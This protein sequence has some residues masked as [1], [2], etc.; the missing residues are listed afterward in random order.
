MQEIPPINESFLGTAIPAPTLDSLGNAAFQ[1]QM[2]HISR[3]SFVFFLG[4]LFT[5]ATGYLFKVYLARA[6]GAEA[7]GV[8]ALG[9]TII[10]LLG[11]FN[12]FGLPQ[13]AVRFVAAYSATGRV[14]PLRKFIGRGISLLLISNVL[15]GG[16]LL[17]MGPRLAIRLYHTRALSK[18][19]LLFAMIMLFG[20]IAAFLG[21]VLAGYKDVVRRTV[22]TNFIGT[23]LTMA[24]SIGLIAFGLGLRGYILA[25]LLSAVV[26]VG[27]LAFAVLRLT[28]AGPSFLGTMFSP[29]EKEVVSFSAFAFGVSLLEFLMAQSDKVLIGIYLDARNVGIYAVAM[30]LVS[31]VSIILQ[32]INQIFSP[33]ISDLHTRGQH[34]MLARIFQ[35]LT[36]WSLGLT[37]PLAAV[38]IIFAP[39]LMRIFGH[40]FE[41]GWSVL[42]VGTVG[43]MVNCGVGSVGYLLLMSGHQRDLVRIQTV[44]T[45]VMVAFGILFIPRWG[46]LGAATAAAITNLVSNMW[47]L[48]EVHRKLA[49]SPYNVSYFRLLFP[50]T[51]MLIVLLI[52]HQFLLGRC[53]DWI[54]VALALVAAYIAFVGIVL[55]SGLDSSDR[56]ILDA[57]WSR[58]GGKFHLGGAGA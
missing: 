1:S 58:L 35:T 45:V 48:S 25:Q 39:V 20:A 46:I 30:A 56:I 32:S 22:I 2:G 57:I 29:L 31:F 50:L 33:T 5:A 24:L 26:V 49:M 18:Y 11:V 36:K 27:L 47:C 12:A 9:M 8:Y 52:E 23:P 15:L 6:L 42:V 14:G 38:M 54:V 17:V 4:T 43:Q 51:A 37:L 34:A 16:A 40:D 55:V 19:F 28:P 41:V 13:A 53:S 3:H 44:M 7:L 21:Q 10:G